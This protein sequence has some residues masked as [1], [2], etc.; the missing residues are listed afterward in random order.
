MTDITFPRMSDAADAKGVVVTWFVESGEAVT[1]ET[2]VAE[3]A[4][5]K[6]DQEVRPASSG[7]ITIVVPENEEVPQ[8]AVIATV[9]DP[10][11][12]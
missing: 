3:V 11:G 9:S 2:L 12:S 5:D 6:V 1:P 7:T 10:E 8:G 4:M